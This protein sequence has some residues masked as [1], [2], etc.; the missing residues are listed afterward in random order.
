[1]TEATL[2]THTH[3]DFHTQK[4]LSTNSSRHSVKTASVCVWR[5]W[6]GTGVAGVGRLASQGWRGGDHNLFQAT[7]LGKSSRRGR[8]QG[9]D[10]GRFS[11]NQ[12]T[13]PCPTYTHTHTHTRKHFP[14]PLTHTHTYTHQETLSCLTYTHTHIYTHTHTHTPASCPPQQ[15]PG[16]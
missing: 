15:L 11:E 9:R 13:L 2:H 4:N 1:M 6:G 14:A 8:E 5:G 10:L 16:A 12:E 3:K 7:P